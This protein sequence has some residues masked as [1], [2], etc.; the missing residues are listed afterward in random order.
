M[1]MDKDL[2]KEN[3]D[4]NLI[5]FHLIGQHVSYRQ[6][7]PDDR[8]HFTADDYAKN[9]PIST[10]NVAVFWQIMTMPYYIMTPLYTRLSNAS[11]TKMPSLSICLTMVRNVMKATEDLY[12]GTIQQP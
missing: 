4:H 2:E 11:R 1:I 7:F 6:R 12:V 8:R 9:A 5:I 10:N 3:T